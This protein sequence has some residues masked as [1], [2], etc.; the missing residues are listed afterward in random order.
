MKKLDLHP[1]AFHVQNYGRFPNRAEN[2]VCN[3]HFAVFCISPYLRSPETVTSTDSPILK[4]VLSYLTAMFGIIP[5][6]NT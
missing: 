6:V 5:H 4:M 2:T 3:K 1:S